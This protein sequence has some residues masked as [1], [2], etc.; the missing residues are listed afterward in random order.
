MVDASQS[1]LAMLV[2]VTPYTILYLINQLLLHGVL[3]NIHY[4]FFELIFVVAFRNL[5]G[6]PDI[7]ERL[8]PSRTKAEPIALANKVEPVRT[9]LVKSSGND[10]SNPSTTETDASSKD[11]GTKRVVKKAKKKARKPAK[12]DAPYSKEIEAME[13]KF[14]NYVENDH[15]WEKVFEESSPTPI[16]V[17]QY[18]ERPMCYKVVAIL[19]NKPAVAFDLLCDVERR[20]EWD[21]LCVEAKTLADISPGVKVHYLRTKGM[22]PTASRDTVV[23]AYVKEIGDNGTYCNVTTSIEHPAMPERTKEKI[24]R[25][26]TTIAGQIIGPVENQ[27]TKCRLIQVLDADLKGSIPQRLIQLV[28]TKAVPEG[29]RNVNAQLPTLKAY[30]KSKIIEIATEAR[31]ALESAAGSVEVSGDDDDLEDGDEQDGTGNDNVDKNKAGSSKL[32]DRDL[33]LHVL[34][35]RLAA[36]ESEIG[37]RQRSTSSAISS[38]TTNGSNHLAT[39]SKSG[40]LQKRSGFFRS[41]WNGLL[42]SVGLGR[43]GSSSSRVRRVVVTVLMLAIFG[44]AV[45][46]LRRRYRR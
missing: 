41:F 45:R 27:P 16:T 4:V 32:K 33:T 38:A 7:G 37:L 39:G 26:E 6:L 46:G 15:I 42:S 35:D 17:Y 8:F 31:K 23:L 34:S 30:P 9:S 20:P 5:F 2:L 13:K 44:G 18:K 12:R 24:V 1:P 21:P 36:V 14:M 40:T 25:M 3:D 11:D 43:A 29:I 22:W 10:S 19:D 28:S